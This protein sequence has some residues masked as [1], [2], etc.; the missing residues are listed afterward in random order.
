[1]DKSNLIA[2][3]DVERP[4]SAHFFIYHKPVP[5]FTLNISFSS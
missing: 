5:L 1:M 2:S 4:G 3:E